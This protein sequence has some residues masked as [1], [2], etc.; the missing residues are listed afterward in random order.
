MRALAVPVWLASL[1]A[2]VGCAPEPGDDADGDDP[3]LGVI[4]QAA[5]TPGNWALPSDVA[6]AGA[7][8]VR[9]DDAPPWDGGAHCT[10][11]FTEGAAELR[12][13]LMA[14][15][16]GISNIY[17]YS[18]RQ[19]T[20][21]A[22][23]TSMH[24]TGRAIDVMIPEVGGLADNDVGDPIGNWLVSNS[25]RI[26]V[27]YIIWDRTSWN[28]SRTSGDKTREYTGPN[29]HTDH[30]HVELNLDGANR[31][32]PWFA[33]PTPPPPPPP[34][35]PALDAR[36]VAQGSDAAPETDGSA[37]LRACVGAPITLWFEVENTGRATWVDRGDAGASEGENVRLG[38]E[39]DAADVL[40]GETRISV[41][42]ATN[43]EVRSPSADPAGD[44]CNDRAGC[45]RTVFSVRGTVPST[46]GVYR[47]TWK[48]VDEL[49]AWFGPE[50][51][52]SIRA[53]E[54]AA[55]D[56]DGDGAPADVDCDDSSAAR[57]PGA[58]DV[59]GDGIDQDC[60]GTDRSCTAPPDP[61]F[62]PDGPA[63]AG[64]GVRV[65]APPPGAPDP[66]DGKPL[67]GGCS[68][69]GREGSSWIA[70]V[71]AL[72]GLVARRRRLV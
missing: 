5:S 50:M 3:F 63:G 20:A 29:P 41:N 65:V 36:F 37:Q 14:T 62:D 66:M 17:G 52:Q 8:V 13:Y 1:L 34:T 30:L 69:S 55:V 61:G 32:T 6:A 68:A 46:P 21:N 40:T 11:T 56:A 2:F 33:D 54:C 48:L 18:C 7:P 45:R 25:A 44:D 4:S 35:V 59:C 15:Y 57:R 71:A 22:A 23:Q 60:D 10:G 31:E 16:P 26:G 24:G 72:A 51:W 64:P 19:N 53:I 42:D 43:P 47:S 39:G 67:S 58:N 28:G 12:E 27:Q 49:R 9:Y 38:V 70:I